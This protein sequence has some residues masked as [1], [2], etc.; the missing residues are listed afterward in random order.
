[1]EYI[2]NKEK[3]KKVSFEPS[4]GRTLIG[5]VEGWDDFNLKVSM[6]WL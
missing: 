1:M 2:L 4:L 3:E 6:K 5:Y